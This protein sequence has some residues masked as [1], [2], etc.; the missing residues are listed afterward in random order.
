MNETLVVNGDN[1]VIGRLAAWTANKLLTG[2]T[3][4][5][6]NTEKTV[7]SGNAKKIA[8]RYKEKRDIQL[9]GNPDNSPKIPRRPDLLFKRVV[10]GMLPTS[11]RNTRRDALRKLKCYLGEPDAYKGKGVKPVK[12]GDKLHGKGTTMLEISQRLGWDK[13]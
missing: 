7:F 9:K 2:S 12:T 4:V 3:I 8:V 13:M 1:A 11:R 6:Y 10:F 5:I